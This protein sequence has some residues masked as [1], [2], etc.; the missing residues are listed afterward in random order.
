MPDHLGFML[1]D[2]TREI[3]S[4]VFELL[5]AY[6]ESCFGSVSWRQL[7]LTD[8]EILLLLNNYYFHNGKTKG[9]KK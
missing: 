4:E 5:E 2:W 6:M 3:Y 1:Y 7:E 8:E 9:I